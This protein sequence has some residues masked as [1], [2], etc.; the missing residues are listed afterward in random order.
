MIHNVLCSWLRFGEMLRGDC[1]L[2]YQSNALQSGPCFVTRWR[3][4]GPLYPNKVLP[5]GAGLTAVRTN[6]LTETLM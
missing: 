5:G 6:D 4:G 1:Q 3:N 2:E